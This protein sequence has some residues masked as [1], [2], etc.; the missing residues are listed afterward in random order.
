MAV[1]NA[2]PLPSERMEIEHEGSLVRFFTPNRTTRWRVESLRTKEPDTLEWIAEFQSNDVLFDIGANVG[3]YTVWAAK[4]RGTKVFAFEPESQNYAILN[5]NIL[6]NE[7]QDRVSAYCIAIAENLA[8]DHLFLSY[9]DPGGSLHNF[10][11]ARDYQDQ[12]LNAAFRQGSVG[13][14]LDDL[15]ERYGFPLPQHVKIDVDGIEHKI[16]RGARKTFA[17]KE[18]KSVL[19]EINTN[20]DEH[21][22]IIDTMLDLGF[23]FSRE[24]VARAQRSD[25]PFKGVGNYVF[26]R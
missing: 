15:V 9:F 3:T 16:V 7:I 20:L 19:I 6:I 5:T 23:D 24:Q 14:P 2:P 1:V 17:A 11:A 8:F 26:R 18:V 21:W 13:V 22:G 12:P 4:T 25:G 10:G